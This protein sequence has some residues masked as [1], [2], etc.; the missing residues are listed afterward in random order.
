MHGP[1]RFSC[2]RFLH[3]ACYWHRIARR[4]V[5]PPLSETYCRNTESRRTGS[6]VPERFSVFPTVEL[7]LVRAFR[8]DSKES[9]D[10]ARKP[11]GR[12]CL[13]S[14][15][16]DEAYI[17]ADKALKL[18]RELFLTSCPA[19]NGEMRGVWIH[20][21]Y[22]IADWGW[23]RTVEVLAMN[24]FNA[25][26][27]NFLWG[28]VADYPSEVLPNHPGVITAQ[29]K[30]DCL[31]QCLEACRKYKVELHVWKVNW[32]MGQKTCARKCRFLDAPR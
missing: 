23:D 10:E 19:R 2:Q 8:D 5:L 16:F 7:Q 29:G 9:F 1:G 31:Q 21:P 25:I 3:V 13:Q 26:F 14:Q 18:S 22:G 27:P 20:S 12:H 30:I 4:T 11:G 28:Y 17:N 32:N 24:G 6:L 15:Q